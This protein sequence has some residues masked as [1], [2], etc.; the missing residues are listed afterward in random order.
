MHTDLLFWPLGQGMF[1]LLGNW[2][3]GRNMIK[4]WKGTWSFSEGLTSCLACLICSSTVRGIFGIHVVQVVNYSVG[5]VNKT[6][7]N[8]ASLRQGLGAAPLLAFPLK[9][10]KE[11]SFPHWELEGVRDVGK[12]FLS[13]TGEH[14][15][16]LGLFLLRVMAVATTAGITFIPCFGILVAEHLTWKEAKSLKSVREKRW[17]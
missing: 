5:T 14:Y 4:S 13:P 15:T 17:S 6:L 8:S 2:V 9:L 12:S 1:S 11:W 16:K 10:W 7:T 3:S